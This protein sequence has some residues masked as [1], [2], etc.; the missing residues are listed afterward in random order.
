[1]TTNTESFL[2]EGST[3]RPPSPRA[4]F[5]RAGKTLLPSL[6]LAL[7]SYL[8]EPGKIPVAHRGPAP[9]LYLVLLSGFNSSKTGCVIICRLR[10]F[11]AAANVQDSA[12]GAEMTAHVSPHIIYHRAECRH[13]VSRRSKDTPVTIGSPSTAP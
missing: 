8:L 1:M 6:I 10:L 11:S 3:L 9:G 13:R 4:S 2:V 12:K 7:A 5:K